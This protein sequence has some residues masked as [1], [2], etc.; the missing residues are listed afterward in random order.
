MRWAAKTQLNI[1]QARTVK[2]TS[3]WYSSGTQLPFV[4]MA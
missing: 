4:K 2:T 3:Q 1:K